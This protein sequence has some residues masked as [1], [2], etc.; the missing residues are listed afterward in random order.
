[1]CT[2]S[3]GNPI[4]WGGGRVFGTFPTAISRMGE[5]ELISDQ[6]RLGYLV[7]DIQSV[8]TSV[9]LM[10]GL[11]ELSA[12]AENQDEQTVRARSALEI[13]QLC[14]DIV[15]QL[16][17][18]ESIPNQREV[19]DV[20]ELVDELDTVYSPI[21]ELSGRTLVCDLDARAAYCSG[22]RNLIFRALSNLLDNGLKHT[23]RES[24]V[25]VDISVANSEI[26]VTVSDNGPGIQGVTVGEEISL[27]NFVTTNFSKIAGGGIFSPGTGLTFVSK[28]IED[29]SCYTTISRNALGGTTLR[30][31]LPAA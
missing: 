3:A 8:T 25:N 30:L 15:R 9:S 13:A 20:M 31:T 14:S 28:A 1:M 11:L 12:S 27:E 7:H 10:V 21:Y 4:G 18:T 22:D 16:D 5:Y 2:T 6:E 23:T 26:A 19:F 17:V 29:H 24:T